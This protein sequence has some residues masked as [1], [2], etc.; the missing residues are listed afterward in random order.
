[1]SALEILAPAG[2]MDS[3]RAA[4]AAGADAVYLGYAAFSAR[5]GAGNF[6]EAALREAVRLCHLHHV[7][8]HAAVNTLVKDGELDEVYAVLRVLQDAG[9]DAVIVQDLGVLSLLRACFPGLAAHASTQMAIHN[10]AG[11]RWCGRMGMTRAVLARECPL[12]EIR[13]CAE[14]GVEIEAFCHGAQCVSVSGE[15]LFSAMQGERSGNRGRCA[16]PCRLD[17]I[18][19]GKRGAWLSPRDVCARD[20]LP[21]FP[22][23]GVCSL[24]IEGRLKRPEYVAVVTEAYRKAAD[25]A[26]AGCFAPADAAERTGLLQIF[27]RGGFMRGWAMGCED[28]AVIAPERVNH[29]GVPLGVITESRGNLARCRCLTALHDGDQLRIEAPSGDVEM[30]YAGPETAAG[31][32][33]VLRLREPDRGLQGCAVTRLCDSEQLR[34]A[35]AVTIPAIPVTGEC[36]AYPGKPLSLRLTDGESDITVTGEAVQAAKSRAL[37]EEDALRSLGRL[38]D[39]PFTL[40]RLEVRTE[41]AFVPV[42]ALNQLRRDAVER[43]AEKRAATFG[44]K[45]EAPLPLPAVSPREGKAPPLVIVRRAEQL[46]GLPEGCRIAWR[47]EDWRIDALEAGFREMPEGI[48]LHLPT[49]CEEATLE[50]IHGF[51]TRHRERIGGVV[52]G[53]VGQLGLEWPVPVG[54]GMGVPV[55][56]RRAVQLLQEQ[57][58]VFVTA[59]PE[60][61]G[62]EAAQ[63]AEGL[64]VLIP[65][66]GRVQLMVLHHCPT[67]TALGLREGHA[68]CR[69]CDRGD[70]KS[71]RG[72]RLTDRRGVE[73]PLL[74]E[75]LPEGCVVRLMSARP[76]DV[77]S[78]VPKGSAC[79]M[80]LTDEP[81]LP[82]AGEAG[83]TGH[84]QRPVE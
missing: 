31:Q 19:D 64:S 29:G 55:M 20:D 83:W 47:P 51:V 71:L 30:I 48:W 69:L 6:D 27:Q 39:T 16:Q 37:T 77:R 54:A 8:V 65:A 7:R 62:R 44:P 15:C 52:L 72:K 45:R 63:L 75:R 35:A 3:L 58:C 43:L 18:F 2:N 22:G 25:A 56:N 5:A 14:T 32:T 81:L 84:W 82:A 57:G 60:L 70:P 67:R 28:A 21:A 23:A 9:V 61:S 78:L 66:Y 12:R 40:T 73:L 80:E 68:A 46:L 36:I 49:V 74:R 26:E 50:G 42:S 79:S 33:A 4:V 38:N 24:K 76:L 53:S 10:A 34:R 1:M 41:N 13:L 11:A 17:Y 59:S